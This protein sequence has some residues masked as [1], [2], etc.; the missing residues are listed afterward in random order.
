MLFLNLATMEIH[1]AHEAQVLEIKTAKGIKYISYNK[2]IFIKAENRGTIIVLNNSERIFTKYPIKWYERFL[3]NPYFFR[4]HNSY[5]INCK[6]F[7][8]LC[9]SDIVLKGNIR[10]PLSR[11]RK[12]SLKENQILLE[13][14]LYG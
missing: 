10:I 4:C 2:V 3:L 8:C 7:D 1:N 11:N 12:V 14:E 5:I 6:Y 13:Q 9:S